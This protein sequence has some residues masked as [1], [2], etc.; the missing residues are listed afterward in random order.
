MTG[1]KTM[2]V[3]LGEC[4]P[5][6]PAIFD[7]NKQLIFSNLSLSLVKLKEDLAAFL[8]HLIKIFWVFQIKQDQ[9]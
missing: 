3:E 1:E 8:Q 5:C 4:Q 7:Q 2:L 6:A 9:F